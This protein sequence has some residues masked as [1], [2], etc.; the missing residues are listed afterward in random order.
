M[1]D[2]RDVRDA[3]FAC[4]D[5]IRVYIPLRRYEPVA[6][7]DVNTDARL[8]SCRH[9]GCCQTLRVTGRPLNQ[10]DSVP[11]RVCDPGCLKVV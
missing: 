9:V 1:A 2:G 4:P 7:S 5:L 10:F 3:T 11:V 8:N 6:N